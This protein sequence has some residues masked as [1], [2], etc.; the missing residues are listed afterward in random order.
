MTTSG[1]PFV[2][3][4]CFTEQR[5][6]GNIG[7]IVF[8]AGDLSDQQMAK[9]AKEINVPV[10]GFVTGHRGNQVTVRFFMPGSEIAMCGHVTVGL[11]AHLAMQLKRA[12]QSFVL[13]ARAGDVAVEVIIADDGRPTVMMSLPLP[14]PITIKPDLAELAAGL[15]LPVSALQSGAPIGGADAGLSHM[16]V[17]LETQ[18]MV[19]GLR[20]DFSTLEA[21]S[22]SEGVHTIACFALNGAEAATTLSIRDFCPAVG[23]NEAPASGTTNGALAGYLMSHG[24]IAPQSQRL[25]AS[26][27]AEIGRP[28][29]IISELDVTDGIITRLRIGGTAVPTFSGNLLPLDA[30]EVAHAQ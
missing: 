13:K 22:R 18:D 2:V 11:F 20:P 30:K 9:L 16:F 28:S 6:G 17:H 21:L 15:R 23:V 7:A 29:V 5:F 14:K 4:D 26:Q 10:T 8:A 24:F 12:N 19:R 3:Y 25:M 27:G 1:F